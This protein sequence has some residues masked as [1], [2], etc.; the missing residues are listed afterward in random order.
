MTSFAE[1]AARVLDHK[2]A[3]WRSP[4]N[5]GDWMSSFERDAFPRIGKV[6]VSEFTSVDVLEILAPIWHAKAETARRLRQ[7]IRAVLEWAVAMELRIDNPCDQI[8]P[9]PGPPHDVVRHK[10]AL[11]HREVAA[12]IR[13]VRTTTALPA[14]RLAFKFLVLTA[15]AVARGT[16]GRV[17]RSRSGR[18]GCGPI[19]A[20]L[21]FEL[22]ILY[23][24]SHARC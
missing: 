10:R 1:A 12:A 24:G 7:R 11:P 6:P 14:V 5:G 22:E 23:R 8:G 4:T 2:Q 17:D 13:T 15:G 21:I 18:G 9:V 19:R 16:V 20:N 3:G